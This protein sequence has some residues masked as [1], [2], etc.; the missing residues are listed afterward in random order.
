MSICPFVFL[1]C[2]LFLL[3]F[4]NCPFFP[5]FLPVDGE[6]DVT[7]ENKQGEPVR[8]RAWAGGELGLSDGDDDDDHHD[9]DDENDDELGL[10]G[11]GVHLQIWGIKGIMEIEGI[12]ITYD[13]K[14]NKSTSTE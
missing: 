12:K 3:F 7:D 11:H 8:R 14:I 5:F 1:F 13:V 2:P 6:A 10:E 9:D 4:F